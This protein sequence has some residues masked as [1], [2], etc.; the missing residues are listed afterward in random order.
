MER[1][2]KLVAEDVFDSL[3]KEEEQE[4]LIPKLETSPGL[5][6]ILK[7]FEEKI[8]PLYKNSSYIE[9]EYLMPKEYSARD[10]T[11]FSLRLHEYMDKWQAHTFPNYL[12][13]LMNHCKDEKITIFSSHLHNK[14]LPQLGLYN[15]KDTPA[16]KITIFGNVGDCLGYQMYNGEIHLKGNCQGYLGFNMQGG[17]INVYGNAG[18]E[19]GSFMKGGEIRLHGTCEYLSQYLSENVTKGKLY[20]KGTLID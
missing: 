1:E 6:I 14:R 7:T 11:Q 5:D 15:G 19:V 13:A 20:H 12:N 9:I 18:K 2:M 8:L 3:E 17:I 10:I 4:V 16:K